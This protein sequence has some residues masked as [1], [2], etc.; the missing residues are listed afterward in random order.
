MSAEPI[1]PV[2]AALVAGLHALTPGGPGL[3]WGGDPQALLDAFDDQ[4]ASR[5]LDLVA[6]RLRAAG[7]AT[8]LSGDGVLAVRN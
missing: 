6:R 1:D 7:F 3:N 8:E 4:C 2:E 5:H